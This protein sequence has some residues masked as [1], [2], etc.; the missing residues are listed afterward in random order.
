MEHVATVIIGFMGLLVL[1]TLVGEEV[2]AWMPW[3]IKRLVLSALTRLPAEEQERYREEWLAAVADIPG[4]IGK[5]LFA[6]D[7]HRASFG[8]AKLHRGSLA[9][10]RG[11]LGRRLILKGYLFARPTLELLLTLLEEAP[12]V[13]GMRKLV[14]PYLHHY[15]DKLI[16]VDLG[17]LTSE[18]PGAKKSVDD[19]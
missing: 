8:I 12:F 4:N 11:S 14:E 18:S 2:K 13:P 3:V 9:S 16:G 1:R 6:I 15:D 7:L 19:R 17:T 5:L 10:K